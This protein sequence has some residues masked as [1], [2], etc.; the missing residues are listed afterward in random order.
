MTGF[1]DLESLFQSEPPK[2]VWKELDEL[3]DDRITYYCGIDKPEAG[4][5]VDK[6]DDPVEGLNKRWREE[7]KRTTGNSKWKGYMWI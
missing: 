4:V 1:Y 5:F 3:T 6:V 7:N 2:S